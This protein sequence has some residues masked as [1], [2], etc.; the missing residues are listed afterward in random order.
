MDLLVPIGRFSEMT[1]L[2]VKALR[3]YAESG[4][5]PPAHVDPS[6]G[7]RYY[8]LG[9][10]NRA[11]AIRILRGVDMPLS[12]IAEVLATDDPEV[13]G[14]QLD[15]HRDR[16]AA[17]LAD[18]ERR[19]RFLERLIERG[20]GVMP[21]DVEL[22]E[23][24]PQTVATVRRTTDLARISTDLAEGFRTIVQAIGAAGGA[25]AGVP[26]VVYHAVID[27]DTSG[28]I[29]M[30]V[31]VEPD[32]DLDGDVDRVDVPAQLVAATVHRGPY[33]EIAP[34]YHTVSGWL[35]EHGHQIA[36]PPRELYL[37]DPGEVPA[38]KLLTE[39]QWPVART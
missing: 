13:I 18:D 22:E 38:E 11:E 39:V 6:S 19:L 37:N 36:G 10:T 8:R 34:A 27:E 24:A 30:C 2:T 16:L 4:M 1:R 25:P 12:E 35:A 21:Y 28:D 23:T 20:E 3:L 33:D 29:A 7:Y 31:P 14:K 15:R 9:Q 32:L 17:R 26:Y 5:L